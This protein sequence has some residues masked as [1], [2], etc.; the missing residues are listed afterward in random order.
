M[1]Y[2]T[3]SVGEKAGHSQVSIWRNWSLTS[4][5]KLQEFSQI[6]DTY[7]GKGFTPK[8]SESVNN[9]NVFNAI[10]VPSGDYVTNQI[11]LI[12]PTSLCSGQ[13]ASQIAEKLNQELCGPDSKICISKFYSLPHTEGCGSSGGWS[14]SIYRRTILGHLVNPVVK[15]AVL[16]EHGCEKTHNAYMT[17]HMTNVMG[18]KSDDF[19]YASVQLDGGIEKVSEKVRQMFVDKLLSVPVPLREP[20]P[21]KHLRVSFL[22]PTGV[23]VQISNETASCIAKLVQEITHAGGLVV[24]PQNSGFISS[25][26]FLLE[27]LD[28][29]NNQ[30]V[31]PS[32][33]YG[34]KPETSGFHIMQTLSDSWPECITGLGATGVEIMVTVL[35]GRQIMRPT[36][37]HPMIPLVRI[38]IP[39]DNPTRG[40]KEAMEETDLILTGD[41]KSWTQQSLQL[42]LD[43]ASST[44]QPKHRENSDFQIS[45]GPLGIS[46]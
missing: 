7:S 16:L 31:Q 30:Q 43:I 28:M 5:E 19:G 2:R 8:P 3:R 12:L 23:Q 10:K 14:E 20:A 27:L 36:P 39:G 17:Q 6:P 44:K 25:K 32:L 18:L 24:I 46:M 37:A 29:C 15:Y 35:E 4:K 21:L 9:N 11:G 1:Y 40:I 42:L 33:S 13:I 45:R 38:S 22:T 34:Q 41:S 26:T